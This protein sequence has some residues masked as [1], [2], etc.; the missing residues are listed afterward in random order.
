M[1]IRRCECT[2]VQQYIH[3]IKPVQARIL[4]EINH[5]NILTNSSEMKSKGDRLKEK[6]K[7]SQ[8]EPEKYRVT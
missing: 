2:T 5:P 4:K 6:K 8:E 1:D 3:I 7:K